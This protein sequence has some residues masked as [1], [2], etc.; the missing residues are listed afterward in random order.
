MKN[1]SILF[2]LQVFINFAFS[3]QEIST[4]SE[5]L[6]LIKLS[7]HVLIHTF[8]NS[9]GIIYLNNNEAIIASTPPSDKAT[10]DLI[11]Y[12]QNKYKVKIIAFVIDQ[13]HPDA[14]EG[15]DIVHDFG[16]QTYAN[17]LTCLIAKE[18]GLPVPLN[19]FEEKLEIKLGDKK[20][21]CQYFGPAHTEDGIV[22]WIPDEQILFGGNAVRNYNGW[23]GNISDAT[24]SEW[25][26]TIE[27]MK[28]EFR[29]IK[30]V[31]PG[32]GSYG[33]PELL[34]YTF[35]LYKPDIWGE[36]LK[37]HNIYPKEIFK[38]YDRIFLVADSEL[39]DND[40][41]YLKNVIVFVDKEDQYVM[42]ESPDIQY[43]QSIN[44]IRSEYGKIQILNKSSDCTKEKLSGFYKTLILNLRDDEVKMEI[45]LKELIR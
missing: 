44:R 33:G 30:I 40:I 10:K 28:A 13:W 42:I 15:L 32:H 8:D 17:K 1:I 12:V 26:G 29:N 43:I 9:N 21:I 19:C 25:S 36:I 2:V 23:V 37:R 3:Q 14:M 35:S 41:S 31:I 34:D 39:I 6:Q 20:I 16:I 45:I 38:E 7:D 5:K 18:K 27:K 4:V 22:V 11:N 24:L